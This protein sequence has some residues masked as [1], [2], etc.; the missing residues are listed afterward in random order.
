MNECKKLHSLQILVRT[1]RRTK[2]ANITKDD[3]NFASHRQNVTGPGD[4]SKILGV[5]FNICVS[6]L[7]V[8]TSNLACSWGLRLPRSIIKSH[9]VEK[10]G[11]A[12]G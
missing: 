2:T 1:I 4:L 12:L 7:K 5:S 3:V 11:V 8:A 10:V 9:Q 6:W